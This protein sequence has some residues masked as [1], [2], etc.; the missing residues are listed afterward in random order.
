MSFMLGFLA[1]SLVAVT[2]VAWH[3]IH[4][5]WLR[6]KYLEN[7]LRKQGF[8][9]NPYRPINGDLADSTHML[10]SSL[11]KP[12]PL[13]SHDLVPRLAPFAQHLINLHGENTFMWHGSKP[14]VSIVKP[15]LLREVFTKYDVFRKLPVGSRSTFGQVLRDGEDWAKVR[16][17]INP[18]LS[19][20]IIFFVL[21]K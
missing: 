12:M 4:S 16:R 2:L 8:G 17:I 13:L 5:L 20:L 6:P 18:A 1:L 7:F 3:F 11:S 19:G 14:K 21:V 15:E 9:G 10:Q